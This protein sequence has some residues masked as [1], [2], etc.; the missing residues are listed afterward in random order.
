MES[1]ETSGAANLMIGSKLPESKTLWPKPVRVAGGDVSL[2]RLNISRPGSPPLEDPYTESPCLSMDRVLSDDQ[3]LFIDP[4]SAT[5]PIPILCKEPFVDDKGYRAEAESDQSECGSSQASLNATYVVHRRR[6]DR[7]AHNATYN[8]CLDDLPASQG[9]PSYSD[10]KRDNEDILAKP[11]VGDGESPDVSPPNMGPRAIWEQRRAARHQRYLSLSPLENSN[12]LSDDEYEPPLQLRRSP[13]KA[14][15][16]QQAHQVP[17]APSGIRLAVEAIDS[18]SG[19]EY[20]ADDSTPEFSSSKT[21]SVETMASLLE[22]PLDCGQVWQAGSQFDEG[23]NLAAPRQETT[24]QSELAEIN[25]SPLLNAAP[26]NAFFARPRFVVAFKHNR[27]ASGFSDITDKDCAITTQH[28]PPPYTALHMHASPAAVH[29]E[30]LEALRTLD[31]GEFTISGPANINLNAPK[32]HNS[33]GREI[34]E[35][36]PVDC[37]PEIYVGPA[38][39]DE[40]CFPASPLP[41]GRKTTPTRNAPKPTR[42]PIIMGDKFGILPERGSTFSPRLVG[43]SPEIRVARV[44]IDEQP[45]PG[46]SLPLRP[47]VTPSRDRTPMREVSLNVRNASNHSTPDSNSKFSMAQ[48]SPKSDTKTQYAGYELENVQPFFAQETGCSPTNSKEQYAGHDL[49]LKQPSIEPKPEISPPNSSKR[50]VCFA[51]K[52]EVIGPNTSPGAKKSKVSKTETL[53]K[54]ASSSPK[55]SKK[56]REKQKIQKEVEAKSELALRKMADNLKTPEVKSGAL[57]FSN[58]FGELA[59]TADSF[60]ANINEQGEEKPDALESKAFAELDK[61]LGALEVGDFQENEED[62]TLEPEGQGWH[63]RREESLAIDDADIVCVGNCSAWVNCKTCWRHEEW[64]E[65]R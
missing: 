4:A 61:E 51:P 41:L 11:Y 43:H 16:K 31:D 40:R 62:Y 33:P 50:C 48:F 38:M 63:S 24:I 64:D 36:Q 6:P 7:P 21:A 60:E 46:L 42:K 15:L 17:Q 53:G 23:P 10:C 45:L 1:R 27:P 32:G 19:L 56:A 59:K 35:P 55:K 25:P 39:T 2:I 9:G 14:S 13:G 26:S 5:S 3:L 37:S 18:K 8:Y 58:A 28:S 57:E 65:Q 52:I 34:A 49:E 20:D 29:S 54:A 22:G 47:R 44:E 12:A 30:L